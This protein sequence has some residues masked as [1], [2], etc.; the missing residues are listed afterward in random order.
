MRQCPG[1][2]RQGERG[3]ATPHDRVE[4]GTDSDHVSAPAVSLGS[5]AWETR[6]LTGPGANG[7][8][9]VSDAPAFETAACRAQDG[10]PVAAAFAY[11]WQHQAAT[12]PWPQAP[13]RVE[14]LTALWAFRE[15]PAEGSRS[16]D[17]FDDAEVALDAV[18]E[19]GQCFLVGSALAHRDGLLKAVELDQDGALGDSGVIPRDPTANDEGPATPG[20]DG[21]PG[22]LVVSG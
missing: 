7:A 21:Q 15:D 1:L 13:R 6:R 12:S 4:I 14:L 2:H 11:G 10:G 3:P 19:G 20:L 16:V 8:V 17:A 9:A 18:G 5:G 22:Q